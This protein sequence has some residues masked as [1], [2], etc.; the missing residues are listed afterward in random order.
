MIESRHLHIPDGKGGSSSSSFAPYDVHEEHP[1]LRERL[2]EEDKCWKKEPFEIVEECDRCTG[3]NEN[4]LAA[5]TQAVSAAI[6]TVLLVS[7]L[8]L[9]LSPVKKFWPN[10]P[11]SL[12]SPPCNLPS[13]A[14]HKHGRGEK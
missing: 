5:I 3:K 12:D 6:L 13:E 2:S 7:L 8:A 11:N 14:T 4:A 9:G 10:V 1:V